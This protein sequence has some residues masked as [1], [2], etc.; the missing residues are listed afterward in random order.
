MTKKIKAESRED[1]WE[2][3]RELEA[4]G[5][6]GKEWL[7]EAIALAQR[8]GLIIK[9]VNKYRKEKIVRFASLDSPQKIP[10]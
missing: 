1:R 2:R 9:S 3:K 4:K 6:K 5:N 10:A 8:K 7:D